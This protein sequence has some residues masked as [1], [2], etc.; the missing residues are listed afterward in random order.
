M[1][2]PRLSATGGVAENEVFSGPVDDGEGSR[3]GLVGKEE[4]AIHLEI[5]DDLG[6]GFA[7]GEKGQEAAKDK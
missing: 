1:R 7:G 2:W 3:D 6:G 4:G 5:D